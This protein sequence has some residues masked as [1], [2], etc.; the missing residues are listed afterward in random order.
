MD[1][2]IR[3][4]YTFLFY[5]TTITQWKVNYQFLG[6]VINPAIKSTMA[7]TQA[8]MIGIL[9]SCEKFSVH[10]SSF[11]LYRARQITIQVKQTFTDWLLLNEI[12][13]FFFAVQ[14]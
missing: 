7:L 9:R 12:G 11:I 2:I 1:S 8:I 4:R 10:E 14:F 5:T 13:L 3:N 6:H